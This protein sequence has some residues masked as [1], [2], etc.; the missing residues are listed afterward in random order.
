MFTDY[1]LSISRADA[2]PALL[3]APVVIMREMVLN[4]QD[5]DV[6]VFTN[7]LPPPSCVSH[8]PLLQ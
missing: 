8:I 3:K 1:G 6:P 5:P 7:N 4:T 2:I